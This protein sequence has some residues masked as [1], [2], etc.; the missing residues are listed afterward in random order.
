M[1]DLPARPSYNH[2]FLALVPARFLLLPPALTPLVADHL[3]TPGPYKSPSS[4]GGMLLEGMRSTRL[5]RSLALLSHDPVLSH[6]L[7][8]R[9]ASL[10]IQHPQ[11]LTGTVF[12]AHLSYFESVSQRLLW[13]W[14]SSGL[15]SEG[16]LR[17]RVRMGRS[18]SEGHSDLTGRTR[19]RRGLVHPTVLLF[20]RT[21]NLRSI[22]PLSG[23]GFWPSN[24][25]FYLDAGEF[26]TRVQNLFETRGSWILYE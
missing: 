19:R 4:R 20:L 23:A 7:C 6:P 26:N 25:P 18:L 2:H 3:I 15:R 21:S 10:S 9:R 22:L 13:L 14:S 24:V 12:C 16:R 8:H 17:A 11:V 5:P 1:N